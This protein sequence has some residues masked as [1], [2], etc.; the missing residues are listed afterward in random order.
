MES[1]SQRNSTHSRLVLVVRLMSLAFAAERPP[2]S[3]ADLDPRPT[4]TTSTTIADV[5][6][7]STSR[8]HLSDDRFKVICYFTNWAWYRQEGGKFLPED[9]DTDLCT[10]V[11]YGFAVLDGSQLTIKSH[12]PWADIDNSKRSLSFP[13]CIFHNL[14]PLVVWL[15]GEFSVEFYER[16][17]ALKAKGIKVLVA[18][19]GWNDSADDKYSRLVNSA[20]ARRR[21]VENVLAFIEKYEFDGLDLDWEY[22]VC[23]QV[24]FAVIF[25][26]VSLREMFIATNE[27]LRERNR[28]WTAE[29]DQLRTRKGSPVWWKS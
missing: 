8:D 12:D 9:V 22:P 28:R 29:K 21:F 25:F 15:T 20:S 16:V 1:S 4:S 19:G 3:E 10:H 6:A 11:L 27:Y 7:P 17:V 18:I 13:R 5:A 24:Q 26:R 14:P 2:I 23:W